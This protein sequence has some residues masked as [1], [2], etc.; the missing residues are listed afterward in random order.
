MTTIKEL[1]QNLVHIGHKTDKWNP[2]VRPFIHS[3]KNGT[4][5]I[6]LDKTKEAL[7]KVQ[8]FLKTVKSRNGK[9]LFV[10]TKPQVSLPLQETMKDTSFFYVDQRWSP[11]L[12]TNFDE[13][14][15]RADYY[16]N[17]KQ[18]FES[19]EINK[20]TKKEVAQFK[21]ELEKLDT[22]YHGVAEMRKKPDVVI[23]LDAIGNHLAIKEATLSHIPVIALIDTNADPDNI[24]FPI[25]ANDDSVKSIRFL[26]KSMIQC[27]E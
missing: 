8:A 27:L 10:G 20:Y 9:V 25:P 24:D 3:K 19:G 1:F 11:G 18:Q 17:L 22:A 4:H 6:N 16:L 2:K 5:I 15:K 21:K 26:L 12:L 7:E 23:V 13:I 14:R